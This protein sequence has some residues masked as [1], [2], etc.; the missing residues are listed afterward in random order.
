M[1]GRDYSPSPLSPSCPSTDNVS[2]NAP[3]MSAAASIEQTVAPFTRALAGTG[4]DLVAPLPL[5]RYNDAVPEPFR[6]TDAP[7]PD[8]LLLV[9][10]NTRAIWSPFLEALADDDTL[11][12]HAHPFDT[13]VMRRIE[14]ASAALPVPAFARWSHDP[15]PRRVAIQRAAHLAGLAWLGR[16][17]LSIHPVHGPWIGL[18]AIVVLDAPAGD[19]PVPDLAD[20]CR[21]CASSCLPLLERAVA[22]SRDDGDLLS[23][24]RASWPLWVAVRDACPVG[25]S[26]RYA[27]PQIR[28][29]YTKDK[30]VLRDEV[31]A[32]RARR[33]GATR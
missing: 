22:A 21:D 15:P 10:G 17:H 13:W 33:T 5:P 27:E 2:V 6:I 31:A 4:I 9:V 23:T 16:A 29:H 25:R 12:E 3:V 7:R 20:P 19:L 14:T 26:G 11:L 18:R 1:P 8:A 32:I 28:Y 24:P 30:R